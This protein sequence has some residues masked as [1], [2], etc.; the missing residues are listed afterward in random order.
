MEKAV[1]QRL[2]GGLVMIAGVALLAP[3]VF[4]G[5]GTASFKHEVQMPPRPVLKEAVQPAS[6]GLPVEATKAVADAQQQTFYPV[7]PPAPG[8]E[9]ATLPAPNN[10]PAPVVTPATPSVSQAQV[11]DGSAPKVG[12]APEVKSM[13]V[14]KPVPES[15]PLPEQKPVVEVKK[16]VAPAVEEKAKVPASTDKGHESL[17]KAV[18]KEAREPKDK[19]GADKKHEVETAKANTDVAS[20]EPAAVP[21]AWTIQVA[22]LAAQGS[23]EQLMN[24]LKQKGFHTYMHEHEGA[25]KVYVGPE[26]RKELAQSVKDRLAEQGINGWMQP[27]ALN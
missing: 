10:V 2:L 17:V 18:A 20:P 1:K 3:V 16:P 13:P 7:Q 8:S 14:I 19:S 15:R 5:S 6:T 23:A 22:S 26:L 11:T 25:W 9:P 27:Y 24:R 21:H 4:D 12:K